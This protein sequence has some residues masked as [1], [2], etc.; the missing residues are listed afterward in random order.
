MNKI[1]LLILDVDG[2]LTDGKKHYDKE[3]NTISKVFCD[4]DWTAL[5]LLKVVGI[6]TIIITGD[7]FNKFIEKNRNIQV[8][9]NRSNDKH[10]DKSEYLDEI[11]SQHNV[12]IEEVC[13][14]GDDIFDIGLMKKLKYSF[15]P[16]DAPEIVKKECIVLQKNGGDNLISNLNEELIKLNL[17]FEYKYDDVINDLYTEDLKDKF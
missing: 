10:S 2:V 11:I 7:P 5:K 14:V 6:K 1:K 8:I 13:F 4:K 9:V 15:C 17:I 16:N 12:N 3:G